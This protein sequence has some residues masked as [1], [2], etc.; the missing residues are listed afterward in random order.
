M[1]V[2]C[3][4]TAPKE[5]SETTSSQIPSGVVAV[6]DKLPSFELNL[7]DFNGGIKYVGGTD[8]ALHGKTYNGPLIEIPKNVTFT[9]PNGKDYTCTVDGAALLI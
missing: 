2:T 6:G 5:H 9:H 1:I 8:Y 7:N 4:C 3:A